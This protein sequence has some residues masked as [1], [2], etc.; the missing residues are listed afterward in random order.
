MSDSQFNIPEFPQNPSPA[1]MFFNELQIRFIKLKNDRPR[2][3]EVLMI[4]ILQDGNS[5]KVETLGWSKSETMVF[6]G[7]DS[8]GNVT[9][10]VSHYTTCQ[11]KLVLVDRNSKEKIPEVKFGFETPKN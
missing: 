4:A 11:V 9:Q 10:V 3:K 8:E 7:F 2:N 5:I 6:I 1:E